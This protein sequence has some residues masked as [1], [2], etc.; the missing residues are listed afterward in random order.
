MVF[1]GEAEIFEYNSDQNNNLFWFTDHQSYIW[2][3]RI[4]KTFRRT[5]KMRKQK[6]NRNANQNQTKEETDHNLPEIK[7]G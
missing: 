5:C 2:K 7:F 6:V 1:L 4:F 3:A